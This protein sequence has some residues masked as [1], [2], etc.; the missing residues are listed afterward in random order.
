MHGPMSDLGVRFALRKSCGRRSEADNSAGICVLPTAKSSVRKHH[1][2]KS[3]L[4]LRVVRIT[5]EQI[6][7]SRPLCYVSE[8]EL[9]AGIIVRR[10][11]R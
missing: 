4:C 9:G 8:A 3:Q 7:Q 1:C 2:E 5:D 6:A 10:L 11:P